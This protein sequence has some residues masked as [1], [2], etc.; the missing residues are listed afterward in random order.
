M[1]KAGFKNFK[2]KENLYGNDLNNLSFKIGN[3]NGG[4]LKVIRGQK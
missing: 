3:C 4:A 2:C 1:T